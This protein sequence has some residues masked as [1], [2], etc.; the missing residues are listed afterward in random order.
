MEAKKQK[1]LVELTKNNI[2]LRRGRCDGIT[3]IQV[4]NER[5]NSWVLCGD[6]RS[7]S[8]VSYKGDNVRGK[9]RICETVNDFAADEASGASA[10]RDS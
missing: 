5:H 10:E 4:G 9:T 7:A 2:R 1:P 6:L 3:G 8:F